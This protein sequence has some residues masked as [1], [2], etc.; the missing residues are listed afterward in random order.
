MILL[1]HKYPSPFLTILTV[2]GWSDFL[3]GYILQLTISI[4]SKRQHRQQ[5]SVKPPSKEAKLF[6]MCYPE[7]FVVL[8]NTQYHPGSLQ[9]SSVCLHLLC[10]LWF[11][12][13]VICFVEKIKS[14]VS[15][16]Q[17]F[18]F[19]NSLP[20]IMR[21]DECICLATESGAWR[22]WGCWFIGGFTVHSYPH[23]WL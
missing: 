1:P 15:P 19:W 8:Y 11:G 16:L 3:P 9:F 13:S 20:S 17:F 12:I 23:L 18:F 7:C 5:S 14:I 21:M 2:S 10:S 6:E 4:T 22:W